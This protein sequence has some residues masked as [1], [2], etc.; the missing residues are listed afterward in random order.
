MKKCLTVYIFFAVARL[1]MLAI[2]TVLLNA[3]I[4]S[5]RRINHSLTCLTIAHTTFSQSK[6]VAFAFYLKGF[7]ILTASTPCLTEFAWCRSPFS[8]ILKNIFILRNK[9]VIFEILVSFITFNLS[10]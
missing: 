9:F 3:A 6:N 5:Q 4:N 8:L 1:K 2:A 7:H 10:D